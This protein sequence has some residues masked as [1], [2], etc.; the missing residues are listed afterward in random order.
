MM[1]LI[2]FAVSV[3]VLLAGHFLLWQFFI[4]LYNF[5]LSSSSSVSAALI[6]L[7]FFL[8][9]ILASYLIHKCD[10]VFTRW[11]YI[12]TASWVGLVGNFFIAIAVIYLL[13]FILPL[14]SINA[15]ELFYK[16][17]FFGL[18]MLI[19]VYGILAAR[20]PKI[21]EYTVIVKELPTEW[22]NKSIVQ[23]SDVHLGPI[24]RQYFF[25]RVM[26]KIATINPEAVFIT[27]DLFDG[28]EADFSWFGKP[29]TKI[30]PPQGIYYSYGNHDLYLGL[31][32]VAEIL[33]NS[34]VVIL[35]N[36]MKEISGLQIIGINYS[37]DRDFDLEK[38]I[39]K[40]IGYNQN[41]PSLLLFHAPKNVEL[42]KSA[43]IDL[44]LSGH[45]HDG[46]MFPFN[47]LAKWAH[48]G[49]GYGFFKLDDFS[50]IV[51]RGVGSWGPPLRTSGQSEIVK[52]ILKQK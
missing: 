6:I 2:F 10:N 31:G 35:D 16:I 43:G 25:D 12:I 20:Y 44:Q 24:Y 7:A 9:I 37:F 49:Y 42:A 19:T 46:Q 23:I 41:K 38:N 11:Y 28:M 51:S 15:S 34:P 30:N 27:G 33:K 48:L 14:L 29:F 3:L 52:I 18:A 26:D 13:K 36:K 1:Q 32:R 50:L 39:L 8:S 17:I 21:T 5:H 4:K 22:N 40:Q 47:F 45:T